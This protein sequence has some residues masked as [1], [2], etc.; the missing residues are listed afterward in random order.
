[1]L[2]SLGSTTGRGLVLAGA[3]AGVMLSGH[4]SS[5]QP[6]HDSITEDHAEVSPSDSVS[7]VVD[8]TTRRVSFH[9]REAEVADV[10]REIARV[11]GLEIGSVHVE[12][13]GGPVSLDVRDVTLVYALAVLLRAYNTVLILPARDD[14]P[15]PGKVLV[16]SKKAEPDEDALEPE[17]E[18]EAEVAVMTTVTLTPRRG[19]DPPAATR[20]ERIERRTLR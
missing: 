11:T 3:C 7:V 20:L 6:A 15:T 2:T 1:M 8:P 4:S 17:P 16:L 5:A 9:A 10:L 19:Q 13:N 14:D 18:P 12:L